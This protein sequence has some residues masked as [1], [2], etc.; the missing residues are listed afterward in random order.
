MTVISQCG[1]GS[2][3]F[4]F[5]QTDRGRFGSSSV[6]VPVGSRCLS[7]RFGSVRGKVGRESVRFG[8][9]SAGTDGM[10]AEKSLSFSH[11]CADLLFDGPQKS[12]CKI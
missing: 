4:R 3:R 11:V 12:K 9:V 10:D 5:L 6:S 8:L 1:F 2:V 7:V